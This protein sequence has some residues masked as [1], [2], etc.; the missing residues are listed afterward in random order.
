V[1]TLSARQAS[2]LPLLL[3]VGGLSCRADSAPSAPA[4]STPLL[5]ER[6]QEAASAI[7]DAARRD[8]VS[9]RRLEE[10]C[11]RI[12]G[13]PAGSAAYDRAAAWSVEQ[14]KAIGLENPRL[15]NVTINRWER[16]RESATLVS[17]GGP[18]PLAMLGLGRSVGTPAQGI[19][20]DLLVVR[21]F[22]ELDRA[23][24]QA[25]GKI[26]VFNFPMKEH[27]K[28]FDAYGEAVAYR[29]GGASRAARHGAVAVLVR[30]VTTRSLATPHTGTM[31][32][33]ENVPKIPAAAISIEDALMLQRLYDRGDKPV[34]KLVMEAKNLPDGESPSV[35]AELRGRERPE[36]IVVIGAHLDSWD[37]GC[38]AH[39]DGAGVTIAIDAARLL[40]DL[41]LIPRRTVRVVLFTNEERGADGGRGYAAQH[42][43]EMGQH[44]A[45]ME[46]D[47][48]GFRPRRFG[49]GGTDEAVAML[50]RYAPL[51]ERFEGLEIAKGGGGAD[52]SFLGK[53]G[54]PLLGLGTHSERYF[55]YHHSPADTVDK[56]DPGDYR[57]SLAAFTLMTYVVGEMEES[58]PRT[59]PSP[60]PPPPPVGG[61]K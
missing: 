1:L 46:A 57:E 50:Q 34:V 16:G 23:G 45:A 5:P 42:E 17:P 25:R 22:D 58:L 20:A 35:L 43:A 32:Y 48:G 27:S 31:G 26:V 49:I 44:V 14:L 29:W 4:E 19:T 52:I 8:D 38:G 51:F 41:G 21:D 40:S 61:G 10:L 36:E 18:R 39:D 55:D 9:Y 7:V 2:L 3:T 54:V 13:R 60:A 53:A 37:V 30:S 59:P 6:L 56:I 24:E 15:E 12:G 11:D 47:S 28:S 33:E